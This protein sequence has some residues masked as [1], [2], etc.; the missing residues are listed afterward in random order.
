MN[1][2]I[3]NYPNPETM[4]VHIVISARN[5]TVL[6]VKPGI[7]FSPDLIHWAET[8]IHC[9]QNQTVWVKAIKVIAPVVLRPILRDYGYIG[10]IKPT[11]LACIWQ[12]RSCQLC[13]QR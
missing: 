5:I 2:I 6:T 10:C 12:R 4:I 7:D 8:G 3:R 11:E 1:W 9:K 13:W